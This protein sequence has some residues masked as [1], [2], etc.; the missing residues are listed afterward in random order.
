M[1]EIAILFTLLGFAGGVASLFYYTNYL[2][3][4]YKITQHFD[5]DIDNIKKIQLNSGEILTCWNSK[6]I[7]NTIAVQISKGDINSFIEA[8]VAYFK[9]G[10]IVETYSPPLFLRKVFSNNED[11]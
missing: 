6:I 11:K 4:K 3:R 5:F 2:N 7:P 1:I 9:N 8:D 10:K